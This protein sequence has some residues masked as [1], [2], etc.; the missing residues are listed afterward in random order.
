M[1][2]KLRISRRRFLIGV[3][4]TGAALLFS[5][6]GIRFWRNMDSLLLENALG[7][8][9][10]LHGRVVGQKYLA[11]FPN[12]ADHERL[13]HGIFG[14]ADT[15]QSKNT[16]GVREFLR[17]RGNDDFEKGSIVVI[18]GWILS[19]TE[20]RLAALAALDVL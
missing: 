1:K 19:Q 8:T 12:E 16:R 9:T 13:M 6:L 5:V 4:G 17:S 7:R 2:R 15:L 11:L 18:D 14:A 20:A 10:L 3:A